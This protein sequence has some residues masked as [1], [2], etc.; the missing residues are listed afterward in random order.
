[1][2]IR[3]RPPAPL[4]LAIVDDHEVFRLG[5]R[6]LLESTGSVRVAWD[7]ASPHEAWSRMAAEPVDAILVDM[8]LGGPVD[9][10]EATRMLLARDPGLR[11]VLMSGL[12]DEERV[13]EGRRAGAVGFLPKEM[14]ATELA[15]A[16][17][18]MVR[19]AA[20]PRRRPP[21][22]TQEDVRQLSRRELEVLA[23]I[24]LG[25]TN[26]EIAERLRVSTTTV[27]KH[28]GQVLRKLRVRNRSEAASVAATVLSQ[29]R[30]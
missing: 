25:R 14:A 29:P 21:G 16:L 3:N 11:V 23:Q 17:A 13:A 19:T 10:V 28:V 20:A 5:L 27:N 9:G 7:A 24:R 8:H 2:S 12:V 6:T 4:T 15:N 30:S 22:G 18:G 26:R 1:M